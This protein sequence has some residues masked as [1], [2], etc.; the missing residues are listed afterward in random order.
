MSRIFLFMGIQGAGKGT[1]AARLADELHIPQISTGNI[2]R[3]VIKQESP[4]GEELRKI[5]NAGLLVPDEL[6]SRMVKDRIAQPDAQAGFIL[7]GYPRTQTQAEHLDA[8][9]AERNARIE[10][11]FFFD[12]PEDEAVARLEPRRVCT[13]NESHIYHLVHNPPKQAGVCDVDGAPLKQ[14]D[15][16][17]PEAIKKRVSEYLQQTIPLIEIYE[18][19][20][21]VSRIDATGGIDA[22]TQAMMQAVPSK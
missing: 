8:M 9:L 2:F 12:L 1:Q 19:R 20:G 16:D 4:L 3:A 13:V 5:L 21:L 14:R 6:T 22:I 17:K 15:D 18:Q 7:D 10:R 11:V